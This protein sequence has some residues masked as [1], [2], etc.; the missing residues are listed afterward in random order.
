MIAIDRT[1]DGIAPGRVSDDR[2]YGPL[3]ASS[4]SR[5]AVKSASL[6][7]AITLVVVVVKPSGRSGL[8]TGIDDASRLQRSIS[9]TV[10][11]PGSDR[12]GDLNTE[13]LIAAAVASAH[14]EATAL[15]QQSRRAA[16]HRTVAL[17][18]LIA[19][20]DQPNAPEPTAPARADPAPPVVAALQPV[21]HVAALST[22]FEA[23][24]PELVLRPRF[25]RPQSRGLLESAGP[26]AIPNP[27][28]RAEGSPAAGLRQE[29]ALRPQPAPI[30]PLTGLTGTIEPRPELD[31]SRRLTQPPHWDQ[32]TRPTVPLVAQNGVI[33]PGRGPILQDFGDLGAA[34]ERVLGLVL[35]PMPGAPVLAPMDGTIRYAGWFTDLGLILIIEHAGGYHS[36]IAGLGR[37]DVDKGQD[38]LAG[39][40]IAHVMTSD[41]LRDPAI[42]LYYELRYNGRPINP[43][44]GLAAA[45]RRGRG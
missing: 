28:D 35:R 7:L 13:W 20:A 5:V 12:N 21:M 17:R 27:A 29:A 19:E 39:E 14:H 24:E 9:E 44:P 10:D 2:R 42:T 18:A 37:I 43:I 34:G 6:I 23:P 8:A 32:P 40:P 22:G 33:L 15:G 31:L 45:Q 1:Q 16:R 30:T 3:T 25:S 36:L 41:R 4:L 26:E 38:V 11:S